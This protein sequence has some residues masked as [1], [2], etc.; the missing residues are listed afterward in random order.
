[1]PLSTFYLLP[2]QMIGESLE[3][4]PGLRR[5]LSAFCPDRVTDQ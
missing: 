4:Q 5:Q 1:M 2:W 3:W